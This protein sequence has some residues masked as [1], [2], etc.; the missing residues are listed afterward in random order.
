MEEEGTCSLTVLMAQQGLKRMGKHPVLLR[1]AFLELF[2]SDKGLKTIDKLSEYPNIMFLDISRNSI[3]SLDVLSSLKTLVQLNASHNSITDCLNF[4]AELCSAENPFSD[5]ESAVGS[6]LTFADL[7]HNNIPRLLDLSRHRFLEELKLSNNKISSIQGLQELH[8]LRVLDLSHNSISEIQGLDNLPIQSLK[9]RGNKIKFLNGL[10][11]LPVL[12]HLDAAENR[13]VSLA[14]LSVNKT[15]N[16]IDVSSNEIEFIRQTEFLQ[17]IPWLKHLVMEKNPAS[18]KHLY[19]YVSRCTPFTV[20]AS[21]LKVSIKLPLQILTALNTISVI[22]MTDCVSF[23]GFRICW[24][25][26]RWR[27]HWRTK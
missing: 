13:I 15:L 26:T 3:E 7:S 9:L 16:F 23:I 20:T 17:R 25:L 18:E 12:S 11:K 19:R 22:G 8:Y 2:L 5:G 24:Y 21:S 4:Y 27:L 10:D 1:H 6:L 14:P